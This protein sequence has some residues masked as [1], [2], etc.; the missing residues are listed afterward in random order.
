VIPC[1][2]PISR[3][4]VSSVWTW[5]PTKSTVAAATPPVRPSN[6]VNRGTANAPD[7]PRGVAVDAS[8]CRS[9]LRI[10]ATVTG[11]VPPPRSAAK[12]CASVTPVNRSAADP[13]WT[14]LPI[15]CIAAGAT[16]AAGQG[17]LVWVVRAYVR[18]HRCCAARSAARDDAI[19]A[20]T[21][22]APTMI[23]A[24]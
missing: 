22:W 3:N 24:D 19:Q 15:R 4:A 21:A 10:A 23:P 8:T 7:R 1:A 9:I 17:S 12:G 2:P 16:N 11:L 14:S 5:T 20:A 18:P 6:H 13:V